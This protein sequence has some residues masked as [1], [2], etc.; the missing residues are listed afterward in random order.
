MRP[1]WRHADGIGTGILNALGQSLD[2]QYRREFKWLARTIFAEAPIGT[3][4]ELYDMFGHGGAIE[5]LVVQGLS[6]KDAEGGARS[7]V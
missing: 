4:E 3:V 7:R 2:S 6:R 1:D 5:A